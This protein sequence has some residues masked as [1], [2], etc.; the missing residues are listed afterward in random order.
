MA[1]RVTEWTEVT[2][3]YGG[4]DGTKRSGRNGDKRNITEVPMAQRVTEI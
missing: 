4:A 2:Q 1:H 3:C